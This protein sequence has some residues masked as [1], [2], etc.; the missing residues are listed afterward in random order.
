MRLPRIREPP[1][2]LFAEPAND[3]YLQ[4]LESQQRQIRAVIAQIDR[5]M[6]GLRVVDSDYL[7]AWK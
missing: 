2:F 5:S 6:R 7:A 4:L 3:D 1:Q